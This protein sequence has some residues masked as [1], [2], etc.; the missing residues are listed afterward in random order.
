MPRS[1][2]GAIL[3]ALVVAGLAPEL[4]TAQGATST[5]AAPFALSSPCTAPNDA[6]SQ[7]VLADSPVVYYPLNESTG[8]T[9]CD[10][11]GNANDGSYAS[12]G[13]TY[14]VAGPLASDPSQT[15]VSSD[16]SASNLIG[17]GPGLSGLSGNQSFTLEGWFKGAAAP[18]EVLVALG[19]V[20]GSS[21]DG[22][23][24]WQAVGAASTA[25][26]NGTDVFLALDEYGASNCWDATSAGVNLRDGSWHYLAIAY[27]ASAASNQL[28][29]YAD[30]QDLGA[31][32]ISNQ[33][34][35]P[36]NFS[37][38]PVRVGN[39]GDNVVNQDF[40]GDAA[41]IAVY[42]TALSTARIDAHYQAAITAPQR[43]TVSTSIAYSGG[44]GG[45]T[46]TAADT[47]PDASCSAGSC[48]VDAGDTVTLTAHA[49]AG[50][51]FSSWAGIGD[52]CIDS[53]N[54]TCTISNVQGD[55]SP[56]A[57]FL[58]IQ[59]PTVSSYAASSVSTT[60]ETIT[61]TIQSHGL[62]TNYSLDYGTSTAYGQTA[63]GGTVSSGS[64]TV[65][66][67]LSGLTPG[68]TYDFKV[69]ASSSGGSVDGGNGTFTTASPPTPPPPP[70]PLAAP[71]LSN[72]SGALTG[73][74]SAAVSGDID[75]PPYT[76]AAVAYYVEYATHAYYLRATHNVKTTDPYN[77]KTATKTV[78][79]AHG[80]RIRVTG[81][82]GTLSGL[83]AGTTYDFRV[84]ATS[85]DT[86][87]VAYSSNQTVTTPPPGPVV[88]TADPTSV[89][90]SGATMQGSID[91]KGNAGKYTFSWSATIPGASG[92]SGA[93]A[94]ASGTV[95]GNLPARNGAQNLS[96]LFSQP[97]P[98]GS[99]VTYSLQ[100]DTTIAG[101]ATHISGAQKS[102]TTGTF[103]PD[104]AGQA[105]VESATSAVLA[106]N[107]PQFTE[108][109]T[110]GVVDPVFAYG[111]DS[112]GGPAFT[113]T[114]T[115]EYGV[116]QYSTPSS[117]AVTYAGNTYLAGQCGNLTTV[118]VSGLAPDTK[119]FYSPDQAYGLGNC[120]A[121]SPQIAY[122]EPGVA[123]TNVD[124]VDGV[125]WCWIG[126]QQELAGY[127]DGGFG[128]TSTP[129][130]T[131]YF[132]VQPIYPYFVGPFLGDASSGFTGTSPYPPIVMASGT[133]TTAVTTAPTNP[134][135][136]GGGVSDGL[137]CLAGSSC[138]GTQTLKYAVQAPPAGASAATVRSRE[139][140]LGRTAFSIRP[141]RHKTIRVRFSQAGKR[142]LSSHAHATNVLLVIV[143]HA[144][145]GKPVTLTRLL[146][147]KPPPAGHTHRH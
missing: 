58:Y 36:I 27:D 86:T 34:S 59:P 97:L 78:T 89:S 13:L 29:A 131:N 57:S 120:P 47:N 79:T 103:P 113:G 65:S 138:A 7:A 72:V 20:S 108:V 17:A 10:A 116:F 102:F 1:A 134:T 123:I 101:F 100:Y 143:E 105:V 44:S 40:A 49:A 37:N 80:K 126:S 23:A 12:A 75:N 84:V 70:P 93:V 43:Y 32:T 96:A 35:P 129:G 118:T 145:H 9:L 127:M 63:A 4:A 69:L 135:V 60:S 41:Q 2:L 147:L 19:F 68:T 146:A 52:P 83:A 26:N 121:M 45:N 76:G 137:G 54:T 25:C 24:V 28:T 115:S 133:F 66:F 48:T 64:Q 8:T 30:G 6:Y 114:Q 139:I 95:T 82:L 22:M 67:T 136:S 107:V 85:T 98:A 144:G 18:N 81:V 109:Q 125:D 94:P 99:Q 142:F 122:N 33:N 92:C 62:A 56:I 128:E 88:S 117:S 50:Y 111:S 31:Q 39:W 14:G 51:Q 140:V 42:G 55:V 141:H 21:N 112:A 53:T 104:G 110:P 124:Q 132:A 61:A 73:L 11:S 130:G 5:F 90:S 3:L 71:V 74:T 106:A 16:G 77:Q 87:N 15:A 91:D 46:V 119:Y 38:T